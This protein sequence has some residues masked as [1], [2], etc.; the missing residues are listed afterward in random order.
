MHGSH[1]RID[2]AAKDCN[3]CHYAFCSA[4]DEVQRVEAVDV[5]P[6]SGMVFRWFVCFV[7]S[8]VSRNFTT[9]YERLDE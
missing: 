5:V 4:S 6:G 7:C 1:T 3:W 9:A 2:V 8:A